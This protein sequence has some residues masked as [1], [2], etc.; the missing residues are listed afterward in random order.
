[1]QLTLKKVLTFKNWPVFWKMSSMPIMAVGL[2]MIG[3][4]V[5]LLPLTHSKLAEDKKDNAT[6]IVQMAYK[7]VAEYDQRATKGEFPLEEAQKRAKE[8]IK[9]MRFGK[10]EKEYIFI[11]DLD[12]ITLLNP[13][14]PELE[15]KT[16]SD[17]KD[18]TGK[19]F[20]LEMIKICKERGDGFVEY[21]WPKSF[22]EKPSLKIAYVKLY[23]P[24]GWVIG[25]S[26]YA[27]DVMAMVWKMGI[28]IS[29]LIIAVSIIV[30]TATFII[31]GGFIS[32]PVKQYEQ[33]I[34]GFARALSTRKGDLTQRLGVKSA[35]EIGMLA[36]EIN[37]VMDG[38]G[39]MVDS[40]ITSTGRVSTT[41]DVLKE[42]ANAMTAGAK[43]Q[44]SQ[45][46]HIAAA[47]EE[48]SQTINDI[49]QNAAS[50]SETSSNAMQMA[51]K[52]KETA[53]DAVETVINVHSST[54]GLAEMIARLNSK[55]TEIG[56]IVTVIK[57]IADQ[58]NLLALNA[59]IEA[60]RAGEQGRGFSVVADE[61]RKLAEKTIK[62]T[63]EI[64]SEIQ[65]IQEE[66]TETSLKMTETAT[67][68]TKADKAIKDVMNTIESM[69]QAV[70]QANDK[71]MQIATAV[72]EQSSA[73]EEV[74]KNIEDT[75]TIAKDTENMAAE[76]LKGAEK[77][78]TVVE[79]L[80]QSFSG[81]QTVGST[82]ATL[83]FMKGKIRSYTYRVGDSVNGKRVVLESELP[84]HQNSGFGKWYYGEGREMLGYLKSYQGLSSS[85]ENLY[86]LGKK[87]AR[88]VNGKDPGAVAL[89]EQLTAATKH[90]QADIDAI[91]EETLKV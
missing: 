46:H 57:D 85:L 88:A 64:T 1:M 40:M 86:A 8:R 18:S 34:Q 67:E 82:A 50:A 60:A 77:I 36:G 11:N 49:A 42:E 6:S 62:A 58:T 41:A 72:E 37:Q 10:D 13:A 30:T 21:L 73:A 15:G 71:I 83:E 87:T 9:N 2:I 48:M 28:G 38:Y 63:N 17:L 56:A 61:V 5:Y 25:S 79:E 84:D 70:I 39:L 16:M 90:I 69:E 80:R 7:L 52:G 43:R 81:F 66:S 24:W 54:V 33:M 4:F 47:A 89:Y 59:A 51:G 75:A 27:D 29:V 19:Y 68:V 20:I 3:M 26:I 91:K 65:A 14:Q 23:K 45:A 44:A 53:Q 55:T 32:G 74:A 35:D 76:V 22:N 78:L 12:A 31:G